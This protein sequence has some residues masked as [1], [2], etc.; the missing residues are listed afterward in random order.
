MFAPAKTP[1][2]IIDLLNKN[3]NLVLNEKSNEKSNEKKIEDQGADVDTGTPEQLAQLVAKEAVRWK[4]VVE[5][6]KITVD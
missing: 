6:A 4:K 5:A 1:K 3:M 2:D